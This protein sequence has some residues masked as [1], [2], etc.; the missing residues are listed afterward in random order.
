MRVSSISSHV[1]SSS[2]SRL[3]SLSSPWPSV[4]CERDRRERSRTSRP[5]VGS[6]TSISGSAS[7]S[8]TVGEAAR[9]RALGDGGVPAPG[10][11]LLRRRR[12]GRRRGRRL[13]RTATASGTV[14]QGGRA[15]DGYGRDD[16]ADDEELHGRHPRM[17]GGGSV[18]GER[19]PGLEAGL[20]SLSPTGSPRTARSDRRCLG[21]AARVRQRPEQQPRR[22]Q[23]RGA[24]GLRPA[25]APDRLRRPHPARAPRRRQR[26][27]GGQHHPDGPDVGVGRVPA[28]V[29]QVRQER[30]RRPGLHEEPQPASAAARLKR[31]PRARPRPPVR[32]APV[33]AAS[34][35]APAGAAPGARRRPARPAGRRPR[36]GEGRAGAGRAWVWR[37]PPR[38]TRM[39]PPTPT[40]ASGSRCPPRKVVRPVSSDDLW[41]DKVANS[42]ESRCS[43]T[44][45]CGHRR[46]AVTFCNTGFRI[47][48]GPA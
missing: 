28:E 33:P 34:P 6:G 27:L 22:R 17:W 43:K 41:F 29:L 13:H 37:L 16:D 26:R 48:A 18:G 15:D 7:A 45:G 24:L 36:A 23:H 40:D 25:P 31:A 19:R 44:F 14:E 42:G 21:P 3:S 35:A 11:R 10:R 30:S 46:G 4:P 47:P 5:A 1:A 8:A 32:S 38:R 2:L 39:L 12:H 9:R 20:R